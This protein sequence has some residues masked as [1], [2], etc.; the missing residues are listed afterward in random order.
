M[1]YLEGLC[2]LT[3]DAKNG[4]E[5]AVIKIIA[6]FEPKLRKTCWTFPC[7]YR[8]DLRQELSIEIFKAIN[9]FDVSQ[10]PS[11]WEFIDG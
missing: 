5:E 1:I 2:K 10:T 9:R 3:Q 11:F 8:D 6:F 4:N 7:N